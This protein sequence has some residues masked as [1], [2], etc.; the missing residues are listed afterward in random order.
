MHRV[1]YAIIV[2][3]FQLCDPVTWIPNRELNKQ[4]D[5]G[6]AALNHKYNLYKNMDQW[7]I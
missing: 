6:K 7:K 2:V 5:W 3:E 4:I 1:F